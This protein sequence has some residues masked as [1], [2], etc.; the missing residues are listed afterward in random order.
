MKIKAVTMNLVGEG[1]G[2]E[3]WMVDGIVLPFKWKV[4]NVLF[5]S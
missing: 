1:G 4:F 5:I 2:G 3:L